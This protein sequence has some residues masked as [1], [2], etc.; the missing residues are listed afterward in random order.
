MIVY[1]N[2]EI[3][4]NV[5]VRVAPNTGAP[6]TGIP[7]YNYKNVGVLYNV[8]EVHRDENTGDIWYHLRGLGWSMA[9]YFEI[10]DGTAPQPD[11]DP[12]QDQTKRWL[13]GLTEDQVRECIEYLR[14]SLEG[15]S[16]GV[17]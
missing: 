12:D 16:D 11:P 3:S 1:V 10:Y 2:P 9:R 13:V 15:A 17:D 7:A 6:S 8:D 4:G 14:N 5:F